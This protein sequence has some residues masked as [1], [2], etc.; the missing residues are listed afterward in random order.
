ME[1]EIKTSS[2]VKLIVVIV[3]F[4]FIIIALFMWVTPTYRVWKAQKT[5]EAEYAQAQ[6]NRNIKILEA[7]ANNTATISQAEAKIKMAK[8]EAQAEVE[9]ANGVAKANEI[10]AGGL[11]GNEDY[12]R[13]LWITHITNGEGKEVIYVPT[14]ANLPI[15]E[16]G[17]R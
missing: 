11:K 2:I 4:I 17:K 5:G 16:A 14:E 1:Q 6:Q 12:L 13:Y 9:R 8:A 7:E 10:I 15:L 3:L